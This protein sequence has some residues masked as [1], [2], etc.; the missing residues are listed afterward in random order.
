M[1][2]IATFLILISAPFGLFALSYIDYAYILADEDIIVQ[3]A[4]D[5]EYRVDDPVWR[6]EVIGMAVKIRDDINLSQYSC[7]GIYNDVTITTPNDWICRAA[8]AAS[9]KG[10]IT[11]GENYPVDRIWVKPER[12]ITRAEALAIIWDALSVPR[13]DDA[14][15]SKYVYSS[16]TVGWQ[17]RLLAAAYERGIISDTGSFG[18]NQDASRGEIFEIIAKLKWL[19]PND[20]NVLDPELEALFQELI[21]ILE[22]S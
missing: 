17:K 16:D 13:A 1:R 15:V 8:E 6:Q 2:K 22:A 4:T 7:S 12:N 10:I 20:A 5:A 21:E 3:R 14:I 18:P 11:R 19:A 9:D